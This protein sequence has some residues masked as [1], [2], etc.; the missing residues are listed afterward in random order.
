MSRQRE[1]PIHSKR[2][3][4]QGRTKDKRHGTRSWTTW[5]SQSRVASPRI[6]VK[7]TKP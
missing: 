5:L 1:T 6:I 7:K 3:N 2:P 4:R